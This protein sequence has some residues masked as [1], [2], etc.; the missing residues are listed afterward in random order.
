MSHKILYG[1]KIDENGKEHSKGILE[2]KCIFPFIHNNKVH[3]KKCVRSKNGNWCATEV[4]KNKKMTKYGYCSFDNP[5]KSKSISNN[6]KTKKLVKSSKYESL[7][8]LNSDNLLRMDVD[9][10]KE[11]KKYIRPDSDMVN[12]R[13]WESITRKNF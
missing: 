11:F 10:P 6:K 8:S 13:G 4:D 5:N 3:T 12:V 7:N 1:T 9:V 2:G